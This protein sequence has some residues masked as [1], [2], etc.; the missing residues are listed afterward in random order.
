MANRSAENT[1][2]G[3]VLC[4]G[5]RE[6]H[7]WMRPRFVPARS[8]IWF[9][10]CT[11]VSSRYIVCLLKKIWN[12]QKVVLIYILYS[13]IQ[14]QF[15]V[16]WKDFIEKKNYVWKFYRLDLDGTNVVVLRLALIFLNLE[17][18]WFVNCI[19]LT[20]SRWWSLRA[21]LDTTELKS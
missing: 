8:A 1:S 15:L 14:K 19:C 18:H 6:F 11:V 5:C 20:G 16:I 17:L 2:K 9:F 10:R 13:V 7:E 3:F 4:C 12:L 21:E